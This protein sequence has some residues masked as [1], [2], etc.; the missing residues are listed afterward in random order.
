MEPNLV[1]RVEYVQHS[2]ILL[3]TLIVENLICLP[4]EIRLAMREKSFAT[5]KLT[6]KREEEKEEIKEA[7]ME[8]RNGLMMEV[9]VVVTETMTIQTMGTAALK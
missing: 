1:S 3:S 6:C 8:A 5:E 2:N 9:E 7:E 4:I